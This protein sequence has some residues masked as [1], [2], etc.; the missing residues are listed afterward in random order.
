VEEMPDELAAVARVLA[1]PDE[2]RRL[3]S[4]G[5][6]LVVDQYSWANS[7]RRLEE[8]YD[9]ILSSRRVR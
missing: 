9:L 6:A 8:L 3:G 7:C 1:D 4:A 5:R 2:G